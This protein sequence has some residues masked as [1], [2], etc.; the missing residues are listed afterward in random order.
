V[1]GD[2]RSYL[3]CGVLAFGFARVRCGDCGEERLLAFS[4][5]GRGVC[6]SCNARRMAEVAAHLTDQVLP[7]PPNRQWVLSLPTRGRP[8]LHPDPE[9]ASAVLGIFVRALRATLRRTSPTARPGSELAAIYFPQRF[10]NP[11]NPH[12]HFHLFAVDGVMAARAG[13]V[14]FHKASGLTPEHWRHLERTVQKR[15]IRAFRKR[16]LLEE[17]AARD[18]LTWQASGRLLAPA[19]LGVFDGSVDASVRIEGNDRIGI[20]RLVRYCA[21]DPLAFE[22]LHALDGTASLASPEARLIYRLPAPDP[23][24]RESQRVPP[25]GRSPTLFRGQ[26]PS[27]TS[28]GH[29]RA[30]PMMPIPIRAWPLRGPSHVRGGTQAP[31]PPL[32]RSGSGA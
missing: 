15:V 12:Y 2:F 32:A 11:L 24:S 17:D 31:H 8:F 18:M 3:E 23:G 19:V 7:L 25:L 1:E 29:G 28:S 21:N 20:E 26:R 30:A 10:G 4:C 16:E 5:N 14:E 27:R 22:R 6:P 13:G 9:V